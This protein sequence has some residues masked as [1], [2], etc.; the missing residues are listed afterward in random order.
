MKETLLN[1]AIAHQA[2]LQCCADLLGEPVVD[3][4]CDGG[5]HRLKI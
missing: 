3:D 4:E 2:I 5:D 1:P